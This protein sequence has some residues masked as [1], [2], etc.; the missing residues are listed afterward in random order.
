MLNQQN[1]IVEN[2]GQKDLS[3]VIL[4]LK[5]QVDLLNENTAKLMTKV[6]IL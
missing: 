4:M 6:Q 1:L 3:E 2:D 5:S